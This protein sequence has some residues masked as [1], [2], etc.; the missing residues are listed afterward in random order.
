MIVDLW[1]GMYGLFQKKNA[2]GRLRKCDI[3]LSKVGE[4]V[5]H[6]HAAGNKHLKSFIGVLFFGAGVD[7]SFFFDF[8]A[9]VLEKQHVCMSVVRPVCALCT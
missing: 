5:L 3:S 7:K 8:Y 6:S 9:S 2:Q 4:K 1:N